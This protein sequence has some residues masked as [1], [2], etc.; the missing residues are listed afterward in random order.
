MVLSLNLIKCHFS[1]F[2]V[3]SLFRVQIARCKTP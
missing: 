1:L 2:S 3:I